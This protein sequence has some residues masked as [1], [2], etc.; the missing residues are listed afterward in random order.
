MLKKGGRG[1]GKRGRKERMRREEEF[2]KRVSFGGGREGMEGRGND[3][4]WA[5]AS[6]T[7]RESRRGAKAGLGGTQRG[8]KHSEREITVNQRGL[9]IS[10]LAAATHSC[11]LSP[12]PH[13]SWTKTDD[14]APPLFTILNRH[15]V[16]FKR[17]SDSTR[18]PEF[19]NQ[20]INTCG[21][22]SFETHHF[23]PAERLHFTFLGSLL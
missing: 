19:K 16:I 20:K 15:V 22:Q 17:K 9:G 23:G 21:P 8:G 5:Q 10:S 6:L 2:G 11:F 3:G 1:G 18:S 4:T 14:V 7:T 13:Y 12:Q